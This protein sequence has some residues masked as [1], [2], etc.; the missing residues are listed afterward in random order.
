MRVLFG[1]LA[2]LLMLIG[3]AF[4]AYK[5]HVLSE[6][7]DHAQRQIEILSTQHE[8]A[9]RAAN[10]ALQAREKINAEFQKR[11]CQAE[12]I[13]NSYP[14]FFDMALPDD[15]RVFLEAANSECDVSAAGSFA[16]AY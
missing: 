16:V 13:F 15:V 2:A 5:D 11:Q 6:K 4:A 10:S 7:L 1:I 12:N 8:A 9:Q 14:D 3:F